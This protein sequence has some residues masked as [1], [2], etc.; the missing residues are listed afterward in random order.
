MVTQDPTTFHDSCCLSR[1]PLCLASPLANSKFIGILKQLIP[2]RQVCRLQQQSFHQYLLLKQLLEAACRCYF[3][4]NWSN[5]FLSCNTVFDHIRCYWHVSI[6]WLKNARAGPVTLKMTTTRRWMARMTSKSL[7][8]NAKLLATDTV[9]ESSDCLSL[10]LTDPM[11]RQWFR[12][13]LCML[14]SHLLHFS[15]T[16]S[17]WAH[18]L[19]CFLVLSILL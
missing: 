9:T 7:S 10:S 6:N 12:N 16:W 3:V 1:L 17:C 2:L 8:P 13:S 19:Q 5:T 15:K 18:M 4:T 14:R 11:Q